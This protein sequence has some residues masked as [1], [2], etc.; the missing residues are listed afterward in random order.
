VAVAPEK[1]A[2]VLAGA[3]RLALE[4]GARAPY[5]FVFAGVTTRKGARLSARIRRG[6]FANRFIMFSYTATESFP[7]EFNFVRK[8]LRTGRF[9]TRALRQVECVGRPEGNVTGQKP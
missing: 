6:S 2:Q 8:R 7:L 5:F 3:C 9:D 1:F 4:L